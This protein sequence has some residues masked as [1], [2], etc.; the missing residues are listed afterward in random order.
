MVR[1]TK[2]SPSYSTP[3]LRKPCSP[4]HRRIL[5]YPVAAALTL[6]VILLEDPTDSEAGVDLE[7]LGSLVRFVGKWTRDEG[8]DLTNLLRGCSKI[9]RIAEMAAAMSGTEWSQG[10]RLTEPF[11]VSWNTHGICN[12]SKEDHI[13]SADCLAVD[14]RLNTSNVLGAEL[15]GQPAEGRY[16]CSH[17]V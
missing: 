4:T 9:L 5:C 14:T 16:C 8:C 15:D 7:L 13:T 17:L 2:I 11:K 10:G 6:L 12:G 3:C 1:K